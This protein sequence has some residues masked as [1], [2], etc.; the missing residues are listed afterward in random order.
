MA[1]RGDPL[2][3]VVE[4]GA[5]VNVVSLNGLLLPGMAYEWRVD[6]VS[7]SGNVFANC[8]LWMQIDRLTLGVMSVTCWMV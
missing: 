7:P 3:S 5:D 4:L 2:T 8:P 6:A 1:P